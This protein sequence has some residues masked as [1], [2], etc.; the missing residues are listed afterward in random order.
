MTV[1]RVSCGGFTCASLHAAPVLVQFQ[2]LRT[3]SLGPLH[4]MILISVPFTRGIL[5]VGQ[6][7]A[8]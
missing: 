5:F 8:I 4:T 1:M 3:V 2:I 7:E 6:L